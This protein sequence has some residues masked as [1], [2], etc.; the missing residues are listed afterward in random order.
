MT[1][2]L[3]ALIADTD[4]LSVALKLV[5]KHRS[6][7]AGTL[8]VASGA[9][10]GFLTVVDGKIVEASESSTGQGDTALAK[11]LG[12]REG[13]FQWIDADPDFQTESADSGVSI[14]G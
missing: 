4:S 1:S 5:V 7:G 10:K 14:A 2:N 12:M 13:A 8:K 3:T 6:S 9:V 11:L